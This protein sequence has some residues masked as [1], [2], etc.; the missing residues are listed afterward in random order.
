MSHPGRTDASDSKLIPVLKADVGQIA[1]DVA[2]RGV[3]REI[4]GTLSALETFYLSEPDRA[5]LAQKRPVGRTFARLWWLVKSLL[6]KLTPA[7]RVLL[8]AALL[9]LASGFQRIEFDSFSVTFR[10]QLFGSLLLLLVLMLELKDKLVAR[11]ELEAGRSVQ[12]ALMPERSPSVPG[13]DVWLY[14]QPA[15]DVGGDLVDHLQLDA[16]QHAVTLGDV[17]G[18]ALPAALLMVK[19]QATLRAIGPEAASLSDLGAAVNR[20]LVRD[21]L[22][23]RFATLVYLL[24]A[25]DSNQVRLLN[26]GHLA[27]IVVRGAALEE[28]ARGSMALGIMADATFEEQQVELAPGDALIVY[29]D[30]VTE[31]MNPSGDFFGE[32]RLRAALRGTAGQPVDIVGGHVL[33]LLADFVGEAPSHD[34]VSLV[35]LR[36]RRA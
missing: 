28:L 1:A 20:I 32:E 25:T 18:K 12:L 11:S 30:G 3:G 17:A 23:N 16:R 35:I 21:G 7:R 13:W 6:M 24:V 22:P 2:R 8:A 5:K 4:G 14:S 27:P 15:N 34:D 29:S 31:A 33:R 9:M 26:A 10:F 36:R 19:L